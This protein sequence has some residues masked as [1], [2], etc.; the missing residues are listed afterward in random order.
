MTTS[1]SVTCEI[2]V[3]AAVQYQVG[4]RDETEVILHLRRLPWVHFHPCDG[5]RVKREKDGDGKKGLAM[6]EEA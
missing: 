1:A 5:E 4:A 2:R 6:E 3:A